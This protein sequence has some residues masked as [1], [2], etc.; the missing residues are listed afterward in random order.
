MTFPSQPEGKQERPQRDRDL[1]R[2]RHRKASD[3]RSE[4]QLPIHGHARGEVQ[5]FFVGGDAARS[6]R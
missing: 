6:E 4:R 5:S 2:T 3:Q 1:N